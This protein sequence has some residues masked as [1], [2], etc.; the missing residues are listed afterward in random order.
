[1]ERGVRALALTM[2]HER[3]IHGGP[4]GP[5]KEVF[6]VHFFRWTREFVFAAVVQHIRHKVRCVNR[7]FCVLTLSSESNFDLLAELKD[8]CDSSN[9]S[10]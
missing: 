1:M 4:A 6:L 10:G 3:G 2:T 7:T 9:F 5:P 8:W